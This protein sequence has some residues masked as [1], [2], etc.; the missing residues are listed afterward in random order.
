MFKYEKEKR[1]NK[2]KRVLNEELK[3]LHEKNDIEVK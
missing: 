3:Y 2:R 1:Y